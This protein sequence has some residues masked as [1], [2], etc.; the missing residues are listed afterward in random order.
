MQILEA[1]GDLPASFQGSGC[2][3]TVGVFDGVHLGHFH[4]LREV[5]GRAKKSGMHAVMV[6]FDDHPK[7]VLIGRAPATVTSLEHRLLLFRRAGI[8]ATLV[9]RFTPELRELSA[10]DFTHK[11]LLDG[12][13]LRELVFGFDSKFGKNRSGNPE[14]LRPLSEALGFAITEVPPLKLHGRAISSTFIREAVQ[15]GDLENA[16][17]M[18]GRPISVLG[19]VVPGDQ[20]GRELGFPTANLDLHHVLHPP[21]GV[22]AGLVRLPGSTKPE[23]L[24]AV[25]NIG[26]RPTFE[27]R[28]EKVEV[29]LIDFDGDLYGQDLEVYFLQSIREE[30]TFENAVALGA[31]IQADLADARGI[32]AVADQNWRI[33]GEFLPI[34]GSRAG[35]LRPGTR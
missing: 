34:E 31:Q 24:P 5:V 12:L 11:Y 32:L 21:H 1:D 22:Y 23:L 4:V 27:G 20:R 14:S 29:H 30:A 10:Q 18:L 28:A 16:A 35:D 17:L 15:L 19:T 33:P 2:V 3:A 13:G 9:L 6:T 25:I 7:S 26:I 8:D